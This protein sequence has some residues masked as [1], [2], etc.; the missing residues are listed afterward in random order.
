MK[1]DL[2]VLEYLPGVVLSGVDS[3]LRFLRQ[4]IQLSILDQP[5]IFMRS[6]L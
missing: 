4:N 1:T 3:S 5:R 2:P 6:N